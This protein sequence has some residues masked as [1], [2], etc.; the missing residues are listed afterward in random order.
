[1]RALLLILLP[2]LAAC[3]S[4]P[5]TEGE[6][7]FVA[8]LQGEDLA[9]SRVRLLQNPLLGLYST[10]YPVRPRTTCRERI[11]PPAE[12]D[13]FES[14]TAGVTLYDHIVTNPDWYLEDYLEDWPEKM[15]LSAAMFFAH[16]MTHVWQWRHRKETGFTPYRAASEHQTIVDPYLFDSSASPDFLDYGY[17]QQASLVEEYV[18]CRTLDPE[19]A[20]TERLREMLSEVMPVR[21]ES[22]PEA[23]LLPWKGAELTGICS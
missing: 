21:A 12:G 3:A 15:N 17:E 5:L 6:R 2:L 10:T 4:R 19:G 1:M 20:R 11:L 16:E 18:C 7:A 14:T 22:R 23:V 8:G 13:T 9:S